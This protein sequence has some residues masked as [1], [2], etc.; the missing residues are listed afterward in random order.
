MTTEIYRMMDLLG[1][2]ATEQDASRV[3]DAGITGEEDNFLDLVDE[4][5]S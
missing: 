2:E 5:L 4:V 3:L 1:T